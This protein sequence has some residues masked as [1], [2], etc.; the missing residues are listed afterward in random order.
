MAGTLEVVRTAG[1]AGGFPA[2][3]DPASKKRAVVGAAKI[4]QRRRKRARQ[5][6]GRS[7]R[8]RVSEKIAH[9]IRTGEYPNTA[10]GRKEAAGAAYGMER[11]GRLR[12]GGQYIKK[13]R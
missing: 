5:Q 11:S 1:I 4:L 12:R 2:E 10:E 3:I 7:A 8:Q 9:L 6:L 13:G